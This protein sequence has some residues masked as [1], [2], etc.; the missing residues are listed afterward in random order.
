MIRNY[1]VI[2]QALAAEIEVTAIF[3]LQLY[4]PS[5]HLFDMKLYYWFNLYTADG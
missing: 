4:M 1:S 3:D 5:Y 2:R